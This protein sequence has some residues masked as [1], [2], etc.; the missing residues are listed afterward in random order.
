VAPDGDAQRRRF[1]AF[2]GVARALVHYTGSPVRPT[3]W[4]NE[5]LP[6]A[7]A[8]IAV[9]AA[10]RDRELRRAGL[11]HLRGGGS[12]APIL[13][14]GYGDLV[15]TRD[16]ALSRSLSYMLMRHLI[17]RDVDGALRFAK[18]DLPGAADDDARFRRTFGEPLA[19][20]VAAAQ[21][22]FQTND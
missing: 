16:A 20:G 15:W 7:M 11:A 1:A 14:A 17:E 19:S 13:R 6:L 4:I 21:R 3:A 18:G 10:A 9:P 22:W 5:G 8:D 12:F 2:V